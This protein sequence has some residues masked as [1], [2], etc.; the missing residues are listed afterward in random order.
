M[1]PNGSWVID[2]RSLPDLLDA[3]LVQIRNNGI[4]VSGSERVASPDGV[5]A[6]GQEWP[7]MSMPSRHH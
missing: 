7:M 3:V 4:R 6:V 1:Q 5:I 2:R